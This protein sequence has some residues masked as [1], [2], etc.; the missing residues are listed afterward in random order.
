MDRNTMIVL[1]VAI[2]AI[3]LVIF[4]WLFMYTPYVNGY[5]H[6]YYNYTGFGMMG[7]YTGHHGMIYGNYTNFSMFHGY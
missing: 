7:N 5:H 2:I 4:A 3:V 6:G 1:I